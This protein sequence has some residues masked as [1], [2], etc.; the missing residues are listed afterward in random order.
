MVELL[1]S[2]KLPESGSQEACPIVR[3]N[4]NGT[5][6][7]NVQFSKV[8]L[9]GVIGDLCNGPQ[10]SQLGFPVQSF[11][12]AKAPVRREL[13]I[14]NHKKGQGYLGVVLSSLVLQHGAVLVLP[15]TVV[16]MEEHL[17]LAQTMMVEEKNPAVL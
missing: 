7:V 1:D 12:Q 8:A 15:R 2:T 11:E 14:P 3:G 5:V 16:G 10:A 17:L 4:N 9:S 13:R 6:L